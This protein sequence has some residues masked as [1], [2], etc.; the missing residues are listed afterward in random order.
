MKICS[1]L[2]K[3]TMTTDL[4][5][6]LTQFIC[7]NLL[8]I[9]KLKKVGMIVSPHFA[10][11]S[12]ANSVK[13]RI[14][15]NSKSVSVTLG[16]YRFIEGEEMTIYRFCSISQELQCAE[17]LLQIRDVQPKVHHIY[18]ERF[19]FIIYR[20]LDVYSTCMDGVGFCS[21]LAFLLCI[22]AFMT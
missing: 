10:S 8:H 21:F 7:I 3:G 15:F 20:V 14:T 16:L 17:P 5:L 12:Q 6:S 4:N 13:N 1:I 9:S 19:Y 18:V 2:W 11:T 22:S